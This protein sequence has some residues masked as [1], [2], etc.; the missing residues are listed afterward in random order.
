MAAKEQS[1]IQ[2]CRGIGNWNCTE[3]VERANGLAA[4][5]ATEALHEMQL[6]ELSEEMQRIVSDDA[7]GKQYMRC[8][9][10]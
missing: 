6:S 7:S 4:L 10:I 3:W 1:H 8:N 5:H 2:Q 9:S